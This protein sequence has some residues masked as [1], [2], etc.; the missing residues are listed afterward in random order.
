MTKRIITGGQKQGAGGDFVGI[1]NFVIKSMEKEYSL[2]RYYI[3]AMKDSRLHGDF[4]E[5]MARHDIG[6]EQLVN[7]LLANHF[8]SAR[9]SDPEYPL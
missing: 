2:D 4:G 7:M 9:Y 6:S 8:E 3:R 1:N 5:Y